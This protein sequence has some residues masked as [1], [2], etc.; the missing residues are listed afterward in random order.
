[1]KYATS[2]EIPHRYQVGTAL[3]HLGA[4]HFDVLGPVHLTFTA[5]EGAQFAA[6]LGASTIIPI[7]YEGWAH[8][9]EGR[10]EDA[11]PLRVVQLLLSSLGDN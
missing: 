6:E 3:L 11:L 1:M 2:K 5:A 9:I 7:H 10:T 4:A 8:L